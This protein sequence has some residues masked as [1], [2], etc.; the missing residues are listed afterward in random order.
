MNDD[1]MEYL[2]EQKL[3]TKGYFMRSACFAMVPVCILWFILGYKWVLF[4]LFGVFLLG[5]Y[6][7]FPMTA[8]E[9]EYLYC[10]KTITVDKIQGKSKRKTIGEFALDRMDILAPVNSHRLDEYKS[11]VTETKEYW[12]LQESHVH[13]PYAL[14]Y[15]GKQKIILDLTPEFVKMIQNNAP[16]KV[17]MD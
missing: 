8:I 3:T 2:V 14:I 15:A 7:I 13:E 9:Y 5:K 4:L 6:V 1:L 10:D 17:F 11:R 12:S 16:R